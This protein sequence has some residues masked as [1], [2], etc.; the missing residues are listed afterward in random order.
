MPS[1]P[2][3]SSV[4]AA[5]GVAG[6]ALCLLAC[7]DR[8]GD[9]AAAEPARATGVAVLQR[10]SAA[11]PRADVPARSGSLT[12]WLRRRSVDVAAKPGGRPVTRLRER[13]PYGTPTRLWVRA[14]RG[15][16][17]KVA[18]LDA[19][20]G[21][22]W[23]HRRDTNLARTIA[24]RIV[25]DRSDQRLTVLGGKRTWST[26]V[27]VGAPTTPTPLGTFQVTDRMRGERF[28][29]TYGQWVLA[30]SSYGTPA[31]TSRLAVHGVPPAARS[32][33]GSAGC[34]RVPERALR[35][36][37]REIAPGTPVRIRP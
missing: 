35:R 24:R 20:G 8:P 33:T 16:W 13:T 25:I 34:V 7:G 11:P 26:K 19:P 2:S 36:L 10:T 6:V 28:N 23:I 12:V 18:A 4:R 15:D 27:V 1:T 37:A 32:T 21:V 31:R 17:L 3:R 29:G 14:S 9:Q 5:A 22:G 30:L